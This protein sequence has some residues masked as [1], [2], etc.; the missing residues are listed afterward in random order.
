MEP[1]IMRDLGASYCRYVSSFL[2]TLGLLGLLAACASSPDHRDGIRIGVTTKEDVI[3]RYGQPHL[4]MA[5]PGRDTAIYRQ[6]GADASVPR[7]EIPTVQAAPLGNTT[8]RMQ[9]IVPGLGA[10]YLDNGAQERMSNEIHIRYDAQGVVEGL[11]A[12]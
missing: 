4:M 8:T 2:L 7:L 1:T 5:V 12:P 3:A 9:P 10:K 11:S 6:T